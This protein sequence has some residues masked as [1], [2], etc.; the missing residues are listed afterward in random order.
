MQYLHLSHANSDIG[1]Q[2]S[3]DMLYND[4]I[5][6]M[7]SSSVKLLLVT[8]HFHCGTISNSYTEAM[9]CRM[10]ACRVDMISNGNACDIEHLETPKIILDLGAHLACK[11]R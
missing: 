6:G 11:E 1:F 7:V 5:D 8:F 4:F 9:P 3:Y 10:R 2:T